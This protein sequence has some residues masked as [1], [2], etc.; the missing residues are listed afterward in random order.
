MTRFHEEG[1]IFKVTYLFNYS[2][3]ETLIQFAYKIC[4]PYSTQNY[5]A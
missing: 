2:T 5:Q 1:K 3:P 4:Q